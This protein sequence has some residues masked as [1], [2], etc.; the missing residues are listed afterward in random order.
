M[1]STRRYA[2]LL[3]IMTHCLPL[4][5][6]NQQNAAIIR[7]NISAYSPLSLCHIRRM[8]VAFG[9]AYVTVAIPVSYLPIGFAE[10][11]DRRVM[12]HIIILN[13]AA[14]I[15]LDNGLTNLL[16]H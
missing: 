12:P 8:D 4:Y 7:A 5:N 1:Q 6:P 13:C 2:W 11:S 10:V 9:V 15:S 16:L 3:S 14:K